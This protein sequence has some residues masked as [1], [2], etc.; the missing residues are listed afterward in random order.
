MCIKKRDKLYYVFVGD[1]HL[2]ITG[3]ALKCISEGKYGSSGENL[4]GGSLDDMC[5]IMK[6]W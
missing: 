3:C 1:W 4:K 2:E 6:S 5:D